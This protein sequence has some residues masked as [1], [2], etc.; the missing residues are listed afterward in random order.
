[1]YLHISP[2]SFFPEYF[3]ILFLSIFL[4]Q[5]WFPDRVDL[6]TATIE[7]CFLQ[8]FRVFICRI[9]YVIGVSLKDEESDMGCHLALWRVMSCPISSWNTRS[10]IIKYG[11]FSLVLNYWWPC[12]LLIRP[13]LVGCWFGADLNELELTELNIIFSFTE[14]ISFYEIFAGV[15]ESQAL[16]Q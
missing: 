15:L 10:L 2:V 16:L 12:L 5:S 7:T 1:M 14:Y 4:R 11:T 9:Q 3:S 6:T 8:I 13:S